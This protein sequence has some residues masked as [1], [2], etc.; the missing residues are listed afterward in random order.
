MFALKRKKMIEKEITKSQGAKMTLESQCLALESAQTN[1]EVFRSMKT[2]ADTLKAMHGDLYVFFFY[3]YV[4]M[5]YIIYLCLYC[6]RSYA[7]TVMLT[8]YRI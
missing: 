8:K 3:S 1:I 2:G 5:L 7:T 6:T 4:L